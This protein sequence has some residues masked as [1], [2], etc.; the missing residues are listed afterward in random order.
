VVTGGFPAWDREILTPAT[1]GAGDDPLARERAGFVAYFTGAATAA[2]A[3]AS[4]PRAIVG[5]G[6]KKA[7]PAGGCS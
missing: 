1:T 4:A 7:K 6:G 2:P 5:G 3:A